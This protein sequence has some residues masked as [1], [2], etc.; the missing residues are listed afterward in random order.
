MTENW[1][2][3]I[4]KDGNVRREWTQE[5]NGGERGPGCQGCDFPRSLNGKINRAIHSNHK[6]QEGGKRSE[7]RHALRG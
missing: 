1:V 7:D 6:S 3:K 4:I 2:G 5:D